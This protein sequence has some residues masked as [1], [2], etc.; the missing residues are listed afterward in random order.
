MRHTKR[1]GRKRG[2]I[3]RGRE[4]W[5]TTATTGGG[6]RWI[7]LGDQSDGQA[8]AAGESEGAVSGL[9]GPAHRALGTQC[10][11]GQWAVDG[12]LDTVDSVQWAG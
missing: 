9:A 6:G 11:R 12:G 5:F 4:K 7:K 3:D 10:A 2:V 1:K 8:P